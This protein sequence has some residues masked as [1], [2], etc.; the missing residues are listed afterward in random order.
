M[1]HLDALMCLV[2]AVGNGADANGFRNCN[3]EIQTEVLNLA[4]SL[5]TEIHE[6][7]DQDSHDRSAKSTAKAGGGCNASQS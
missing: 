2:T 4:A 7:H 6:L 1:R 5:A 3:V